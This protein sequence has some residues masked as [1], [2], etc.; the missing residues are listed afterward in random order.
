MFVKTGF[1]KINLTKFIS[2]AMSVH[3]LKDN[4]L[5]MSS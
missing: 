2:E 5:A 3:D 4:Q 1:Q